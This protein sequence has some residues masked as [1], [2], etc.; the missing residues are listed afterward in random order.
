M[1]DL[2]S[3]LTALRDGRPLPKCD[4]RELVATQTFC[5]HPLGFLQGDVLV[6]SGGERLRVH[7]WDESWTHGQ[8]AD[9]SIHDH[10]YDLRSAVLVGALEHRYFRLNE[11][12]GTLHTVLAVQYDP[13]GSRI[14][15]LSDEVGVLFTG[16]DVVKAGERWA[17]DAGHFHSTRVVTATAA[18]IV[19]TSEAR[20]PYAR[21]LSRTVAQSGLSFRRE[22][23]SDVTVSRWLERALS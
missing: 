15:R 8:G 23:A 11:P 19:W 17:M 6:L 14:T 7:L 22:P 10:V 1:I 12:A 13:E 18:S 5:V 3:L 16:R 4:L 20:V 9:V 21:V 2:I